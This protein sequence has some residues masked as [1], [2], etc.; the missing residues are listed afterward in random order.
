MERPWRSALPRARV[1]PP[2][3]LAA[4]DEARVLLAE[5]RSHAAELIAD[6]ER[7]AEEIRSRAEEAGR[8]EGLAYAQRLLV[9]IQQARLRA[10]EA[11]ELRRT[12]AELAL[13]MTRRLLGSA[14]ALEPGHW[15]MAVVE[16]AVPLRRTRAISLRVSPSSAAAVRAQ[17]PAE[18]ASGTV[19]LVEDPAIDEAGCVAVSDCGRVDGRLSKMIAAFRGP[20]GL[21]D[22]P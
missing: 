12:A 15:A 22:G 6:A 4:R 21:E 17:L 16:A 7:A 10:L 5:A 14:W 8:D 20:L 19:N 18:L 9:E 13:E 11:G 3:T 2:A 1:L